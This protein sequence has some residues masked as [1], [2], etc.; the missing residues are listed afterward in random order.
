MNIKV[1]EALKKALLEMKKKTEPHFLP[2]S[3]FSVS[4]GAKSYKLLF[5]LGFFWERG[6]DL[7]Q[8]LTIHIP[9]TSQV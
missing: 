6:L 5:N 4:P 3:D 8:G 1:K 7:D 9:H 2:S